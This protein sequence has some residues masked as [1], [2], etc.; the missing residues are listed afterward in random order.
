MTQLVLS[1][2]EWQDMQCVRAA[3]IM[4][5]L[6]ELVLLSFIVHERAHATGRELCT[7]C[8]TVIEVNVYISSHNMWLIREVF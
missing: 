2:G 5:A 6:S 7:P 8:A 3:S 1:G 4:R